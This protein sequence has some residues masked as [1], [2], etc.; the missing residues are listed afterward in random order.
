MI[1]FVVWITA[2]SVK[3]EI[4]SAPSNE[5]NPVL[6][7]TGEASLDQQSGQTSL[8]IVGDAE[9]PSFYIKFDDS[10][11]SSLTDGILAFRVRLNSVKNEKKPAYDRVLQIGIDANRDGVLDLFV[12]VDHSANNDYNAIWQAGLDANTS[13]DTLSISSEPALTYATAVG[14]NYYFAAVTALLD[15]DAQTFDVDGGG[16]NDWFLS[17]SI[18]FNDIV[19]QLSIR[20]ITADQN[21]HFGYVVTTSLKSGSAE[22]DI[23]GI[24]SSLDSSLSWS[25]L[26]ASSVPITPIG[27]MPEPTSGALIAVGFICVLVRRHLSR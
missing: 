7:A 26:S 11:T 22:Q 24:D 20:D 15:P 12:G 13:P 25:D 4:V 14:D 2:L 10:E 9:N 5:W 23:L 1:A 16:Q 18:N 21:T 6:Y 8:D 3:A 27:A 17:F 19:N